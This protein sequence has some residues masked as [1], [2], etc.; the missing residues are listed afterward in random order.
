MASLTIELLVLFESGG[1]NADVELTE[2]A[3][4]TVGDDERAESP[5]SLERLVAMLL[6]SVLVNGSTRQSGIA[7]SDLL[8]LPDEVLQ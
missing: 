5:Q 8:S 7:P 3:E 1:E 6:C 4:L 2:L